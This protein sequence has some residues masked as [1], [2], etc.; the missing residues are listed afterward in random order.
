VKISVTK[1]RIM[2]GEQ[3]DGGLCPIALA[4]TEDYP[5]FPLRMVENS[6]IE[7]GECGTA[8]LP[9]EA[10]HFITRFDLCELLERDDLEPF[11]FTL[12]VPAP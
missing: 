8:R 4:I 9:N 5:S 3:G 10:R 12:E 7:F 6:H 2:R 11:E 1:D